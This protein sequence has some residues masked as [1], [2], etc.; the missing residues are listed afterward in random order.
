MTSSRN[1][2]V[3]GGSGF[4]GHAVVQALVAAGYTVRVP[5]REPDKALELK[6]L[7]AVGQVVPFLASVRADAAVALAAEGCAV[8]INLIGPLCEKN[9]KNGGLATV[10]TA[11]RLARV[12]KS[13]GV[14][15]FI[16]ISF[17]S[18]GGDGRSCYAQTKIRGE[19]AVCAFFPS[20]VILRPSLM[21]G[22]RDRFFTR[23]ALMAR[24]WFLLPL[25]GGGEV[26]FQPIYVGDV[27]AAIVASLGDP[28]AQGGT[29]NLVGPR[30]YSLRELGQE[31]LR[32]TGR[33]RPFL[34]VPVW[35]ARGLVRFLSLLPQPPIT[36][37]TLEF[38]AV[39][40]VAQDGGAL[41][42]WGIMP[43]ALED[44]L[45]TYLC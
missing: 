15:H 36:Q 8:A 27:A 34:P 42:R 18:Q 25:L 33:K 30:T 43:A 20:A 26:R 9:K 41:P 44:I 31:V 29:F 5:T 39:D 6:V 37:G 32:V 7:G 45:P 28:A 16:H 1:A 24:Y 38:L 14:K 40:S 17:L 21:F 12:A 11:A 35:L 2:I 3:F 13:V 19:E 4:L 23:L 10:E 22:P